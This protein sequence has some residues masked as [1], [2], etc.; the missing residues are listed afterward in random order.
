MARDKVE[1]NLNCVAFPLASDSGATEKVD[2]DFYTL[3]SVQIVAKGA[4]SSDTFTSKGTFALEQSNDGVKWFPVLD[5]A[6]SPA[7]ITFP[8]A[9]IGT[10]LLA[11]NIPISTKWWRLSWTKNNSTG[12]TATVWAMLKKASH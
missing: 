10:T 8:I 7:A 11:V 3:G 6:A 12:G 2:V 5:N 9:A 1:S 4:T